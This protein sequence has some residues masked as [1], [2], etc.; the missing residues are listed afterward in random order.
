MPGE[1]SYAGLTTRT[2]KGVAAGQESHLLCVRVRVGG[3]V[4][5]WCRTFVLLPHATVL[6][7]V[8]CRSATGQRRRFSSSRCFGQPWAQFVGR[9]R[10]V[11][12]VL[13]LSL[14]LRSLLILVL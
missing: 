9:S 6:A 5:V 1:L 4:G 3:R 13:Y 2:L 14:F 7:G 12:W 11:V 10:D 8:P